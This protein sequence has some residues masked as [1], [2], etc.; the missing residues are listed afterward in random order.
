M[1]VQAARADR[2]VDRPDPGCAAV[3][4]YGPDTGLVRERCRRAVKAIVDDPSDPFRVAEIAGAVLKD[5]P[6][7]LADEVFAMSLV[8]GRRAVWVRGAGDAEAG[9]LKSVLADGPDADSAFIVVEAGDLGPRSALRVLFE[10]A[11]NA[12][13]VPCYADDARSLQGLIEEIMTSHG[14]SVAPDA[15]TYL[16]EHLGA[17]RAL[18]RNELEKLALFAA[19][20]GHVGI[21]DAITC[22]GDSAATATDDII[23]AVADGDPAVAARCFYRA[24][25]EGV[26]PVQVLRAAQRHFQRLKLC[27][28]RVA[29]GVPRDKAVSALRPPVFF[30]R[31]DAF[32][33]QLD[34]WR[35]QTIDQ[36]LLILTDAE[37][38]CKTTGTP[39][40]AACEHALLRLAA[41]GRRRG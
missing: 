19:D 37:V 32:R 10:K 28:D 33:R 31:A 9:P 38:A 4:V 1:K 18:S 40:R 17:D 25:Q 14:L 39:A 27:A 26:E 36:A 34:R 21:D 30:K 15:A 11:E 7:R 12:A 5:D 35:P 24:S 20:K 16:R 6:A 8:G 23:Y 13:A 2:F 22:I 41:A 3:L 29:A